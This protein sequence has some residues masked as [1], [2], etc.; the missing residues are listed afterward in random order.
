ME[1]DLL[2]EVVLGVV[3]EPVRESRLL[4]VLVLESSITYKSQQVGL[5]V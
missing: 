5:E 3:V 2:E 4:Q 1:V